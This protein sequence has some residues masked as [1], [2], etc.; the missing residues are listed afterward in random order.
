MIN[1]SC[2]QTSGTKCKLMAW[3]N[4]FKEQHFS[5]S[6]HLTIVQATVAKILQNSKNWLSNVYECVSRPLPIVPT[7]GV[8]DYLLKGSLKNKLSIYLE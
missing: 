4:G 2:F 5:V 8:E 1:L 7:A 6:S 3:Q